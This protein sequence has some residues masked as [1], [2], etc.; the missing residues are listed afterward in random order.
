MG[1]GTITKGEVPG[2]L[3]AAIGLVVMYGVFQGIWSKRND[4]TSG[5]IWGSLN[6]GRRPTHGTF[7]SEW[8]TTGKIETGTFNGI[9]YGIILIGQWTNI[10]TRETNR[11]I[12]LL[13]LNQSHF[14][15]ILVNSK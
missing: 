3:L 13:R 15:A 8:N 14:T 7:N 2:F 11:V 12:G 10:V 9:F 5:F 1:K 4:N 6:L